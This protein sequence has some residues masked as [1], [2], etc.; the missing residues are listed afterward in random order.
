MLASIPAGRICRTTAGDGPPTSDVDPRM[1]A[2]ILGAAG[3]LGTD[4]CGAVPPGVTVT[5][6]DV[7]DVDITDRTQ[8]ASAL[9]ATRPDWV[10]NAAAYTAVDRAETEPAVAESVNALGPRFVAEE[11]ARRR[12]AV[13]HF[14]TDYVFP[15]TS[16]VPYRESDP[17]APV[18]TYGESKWRG[19][20]AVRASGA[21][22]LILRTQWLFGRAGKSF[23]R[24]MWERASARLPTRVVN[25]QRGR[26]TYTRDLATA[27]WRLIERRTSGTVHVTNGGADATW[28]DV[29]REVFGRAGA[30][31]M[32][33]PCS[34][35]D[36]RT[37]AR[38]PAYSVL[39]TERLE[40]LLGAPLPDWR[41]ALRR[42]LD[43]LAPAPGASERSPGS[44]GTPE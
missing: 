28:Y 15:G 12:I 16:E 10:I 40:R 32:L 11:A 20:G 31:S 44:T 24:I 8:V 42:F 33:S 30:E 23:P 34:T 14:S 7:G 17:V 43:E 41:D 6:L 5:G 37:P 9:D 36:Y 3:M 25:D 21:H 38:R 29:A 4:L 19:E 2:L 13:A 22:A 18:N 26:P 39:R 1:H 35:A 27:T